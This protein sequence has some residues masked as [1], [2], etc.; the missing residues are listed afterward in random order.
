MTVEEDKETETY[1]HLFNKK[2]HKYEK[3]IVEFLLDIASSK[4]VNPKVSTISSYLLLH[5]KLTQ[6]ELKEL[7]GFSMG[8]ISTLLSVMTGAGTFQKERIPQTHTFLYSFPGKL[9][10]L[11]T[12]GIEIA[13]SSFGPLESYLKNQKKELKKLAEQSKEGAED[14]LQRIEELLETFEIYK[15]LF[16]MMTRNSTNEALKDLSSKSFKLTRSEEREVKKISFDP[17]VYIIEDDIIYQLV[18]SPLF[19]GRDPM[20]IRILGYFITR[21]YLTQ[22]K[23]QKITGL[24]AGK[25]SE[26]VNRLLENGLVEKSD[27]S[28]KGKITYHAES[29]G[30]IL[31]KFSRS[32]INRMTKWNNELLKMRAEL[33]ENRNYLKTLNG[34][35]RIYKINEFLLNSISKYQIFIDLVDKV[36]ESWN[37]LA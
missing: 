29:A 25:I 6:K 3:I 35:A 2:L 32:I 23:L 19:T 7:T 30:L 37:K 24:S 8:S 16:P 36:L 15:T 33:E 21:K 11:T 28:P 18:I 20:F 22:K 12:K 14:L 13:L 5:E 27:I 34:Y 1:S 4:R 31:L 26:E 9:E 17:E 10:D